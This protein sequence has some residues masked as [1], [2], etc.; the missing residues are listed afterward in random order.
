[1]LAAWPIWR[2][3][4]PSKHL[5]IMWPAAEERRRSPTARI[6]RAEKGQISRLNWAIILPHKGADFRGRIQRLPQ[7][8]SQPLPGAGV[9]MRNLS[10]NS[11]HPKDEVKDV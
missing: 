8:D 10:L 2:Q 4:F 1:M 5:S 11:R 9:A 3:N 7:T 6:L